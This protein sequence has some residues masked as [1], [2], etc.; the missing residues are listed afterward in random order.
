MDCNDEIIREIADLIECGQL[1]YIHVKDRTIEYHPQKI[2]LFYGEPNP[3][4]DILDKVRSEKENYIEIKQMSTHQFFEVIEDFI[5]SV[6]D[7]DVFKNALE[8]ILRR[9][10]PF[11]YFKHY[12]ET[13]DYRMSWFKFKADRN[14][15]WVKLQLNAYID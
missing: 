4:Q 15:Q 8:K 2:N 12:V 6:V 13:S 10:K 5:V 3:W 14:F 11:S 9:P 1:C 7:S